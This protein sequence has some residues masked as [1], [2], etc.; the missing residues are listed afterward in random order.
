MALDFNPAQ[1]GEELLNRLEPAGVTV[2]LADVKLPV[3]FIIFFQQ[4]AHPQGHQHRPDQDALKVDQNLLLDHVDIG[5]AGGCEPP[6][7]AV[8]TN[9]V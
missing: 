6:A 7:L 5:I 4:A 2:E 9:H 8:A 3:A 1:V